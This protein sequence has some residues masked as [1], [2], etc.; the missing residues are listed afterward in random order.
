MASNEAERVVTC[1]R[2]HVSVR[3]RRSGCPVCDRDYRRRVRA[4]QKQQE[5][6]AHLT[7]VESSITSREAAEILGRS[8]D[9]VR[10][11]V[12][13]GWITPLEPQRSGKVPRFRRADVDELLDRIG[14]NKFGPPSPESKKPFSP[15]EGMG[16]APRWI[17]GR[18]VRALLATIPD[19][20]YLKKMG[21][22]KPVIAGE[23]AAWD[24]VAPILE[25]FPYPR[26]WEKE[27][28]CEGSDLFFDEDAEEAKKLCARCPVRD[29]CEA[30]AF[31]RHELWG[32]WGGKSALERQQDLYYGP[33][34][35]P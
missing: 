4:E 23:W 25:V 35:R 26:G 5:Q 32:V 27:A 10:A 14:P 12:T 9:S 16:F 11:Y 34:E 22:P 1:L 7:L 33:K 17:P 20:L 3:T 19:S 21:T 13:K 28:A 6:R 15:R 29:A 24:R 30:A 31:T 8:L 18:V 2:G